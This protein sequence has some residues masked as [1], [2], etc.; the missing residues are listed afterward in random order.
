MEPTD[1]GAPFL[2][3]LK[4]FL[5]FLQSLWGLLTGISLFFP[6]SNALAQLVPLASLD[7][8]PMGNLTGA[9]GFFSPPLVTTVS[10]LATI[11]TVLLTFSRRDEFTRSRARPRVQR[12]ALLSFGIG[13]AALVGYLALYFGIVSIYLG[14][15]IYRGDP[16]RLLGDLALL[17]LYGTIFVQV[18]RAFLLLGMMEFFGRGS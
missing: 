4:E 8:D 9:L 12:D 10:T 2:A 6:L 17:V 11:F 1:R 5:A 15:E 7:V 13:F 18:T 14:A 16:R 3:E